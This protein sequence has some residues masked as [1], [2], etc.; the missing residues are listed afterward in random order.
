MLEALPHAAAKLGR[1]LLLTMAAPDH[2]FLRHRAFVTPEDVKSVGMDVLRH[3][4]CLTYEA[5]AEDKTSEIVIQKIFD[6]LPVP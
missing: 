4:L 3:R 6:E 1:P 2:A 5:E